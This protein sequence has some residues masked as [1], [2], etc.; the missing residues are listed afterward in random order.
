MADL[1]YQ[2]LGTK[3]ERHVDILSLSGS[4]N[5]LWVIGWNDVTDSNYWEGFV[6]D[7]MNGEATIGDQTGQLLDSYSHPNDTPPYPEM[8]VVTAVA[9]NNFWDGF[10]PTHIRVTYTVNGISDASAASKLGLW[11][12]STE[13]AQAFTYVD[14]LTSGYVSGRELPISWVA[15]L[16]IGGVDLYAFNQQSTDPAFEF[17][18]QKIEVYY[19][20][21]FIM[22]LRFDID[23]GYITVNNDSWYLPTAF[24]GHTVNAPMTFQFNGYIDPTTIIAGTTIIGTQNG[25][26]PFTGFTAAVDSTGFRVVLTPTA[27]WSSNMHLT[28]TTGIKT[29][30]GDH[31]ADAYV[32]SP[33]Q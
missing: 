24:N 3:D 20:P 21:T 26:T 16:D 9:A 1:T 17:T 18:V 10:R 30:K 5:P 19:D 14:T 12:C 15:D 11:V 28:F 31:L 29:V 8:W 25:G 33:W 27:G 2:F 32:V 7:G 4:T 23:R 22:Q 6:L 13:P